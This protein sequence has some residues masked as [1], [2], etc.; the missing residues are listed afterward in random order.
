M[1][2]TFHLNETEIDGKFLEALKIL[3]KNRNLT[4]TVEV[5]D[6]ETAYLLSSPAN[7]ER[8]LNSVTN[9]N[10]NKNLTEINVASL[11]ALITNA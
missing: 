2:T 1:T 6:D 5:E 7:R 11:K 4:L 8:L 3:F 10:E 9:I